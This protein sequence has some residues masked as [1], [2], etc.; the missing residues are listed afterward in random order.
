MILDLIRPQFALGWTAGW[1]DTSEQMASPF[2]RNA[3]RFWRPSLR[4][5]GSERTECRVLADVDGRAAFWFVALVVGLFVV[6]YFYVLLRIRPEL[7]YQQKPDVF[8]FDCRI[9]CH[10][11]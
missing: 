2:P 8:L 3:I 5:R 1:A 10:P 6:F 7:F 4:R 11:S 9:S